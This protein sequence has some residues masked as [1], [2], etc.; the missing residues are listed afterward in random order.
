LPSAR[1]PPTA[2]RCRR[3]VSL[4]P[5]G[6]VFCRRARRQAVCTHGKPSAGC[7]QRLPVPP[8]VLLCATA[9]AVQVVEPVVD[10]SRFFVLKV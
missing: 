7:G 3:C 4:M 10:S 8:S 1:C 9:A 2:R 5:V 6:P